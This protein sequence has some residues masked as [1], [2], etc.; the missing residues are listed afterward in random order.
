MR[1]CVEEYRRNCRKRYA[2][3]RD[4]K[5]VDINGEM[6]TFI[7]GMISAVMAM[8]SAIIRIGIAKTYFNRAS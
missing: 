2:C 7:L 6:V 3:L 1:R 4:V 5:V 8:L